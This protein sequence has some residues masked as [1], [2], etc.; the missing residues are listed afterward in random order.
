MFHLCIHC[1]ANQTHFHL[2]SFAQGL[3]LKEAKGHSEVALWMGVAVQI[4]S[5]RNS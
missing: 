5:P 2:K 4:D 1:Q 3:V